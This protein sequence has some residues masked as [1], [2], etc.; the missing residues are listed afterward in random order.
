MMDMTASRH[1]GL[2]VGAW[3]LVQAVAKGP[4]AILSG[5]FQQLFSSLGLLPGQAYGA[6]FML[7]AAGIILAILVLN[8][9]TIQNYKDEMDSVLVSDPIRLD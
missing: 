4:A 7:E 1:I 9:V 8:G 2:F 3:T 5:G 6:V